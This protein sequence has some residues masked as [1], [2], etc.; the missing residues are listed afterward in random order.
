MSTHI[1]SIAIYLL[2]N[3]DGSVPEPSLSGITDHDALKAAYPDGLAITPETTLKTLGEEVEVLNQADNGTV[4]KDG[5]EWVHG[6]IAIESD[7]TSITDKVM[8]AYLGAGGKI[9]PGRLHKAWAFIAIVNPSEPLT[10]DGTANTITAK[11]LIKCAVNYSVRGDSTHN[12]KDK[13]S[14]KATFTADLS[15]PSSHAKSFSTV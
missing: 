7:L 2:A 5:S 3:P 4:F 14:M 1:G 6:G 15:K 11:R 8:E 10:F 12:G 13:S 9:D